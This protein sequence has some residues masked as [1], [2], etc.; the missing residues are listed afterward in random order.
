MTI[1]RRKFVVGSA[2]AGAGLLIGV[3]FPSGLLHAQ[4]SEK[5]KKKAPPNPF[6]AYIHVKPMERSR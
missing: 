6:D 3:R 5:A 4:E 1:S 2:T